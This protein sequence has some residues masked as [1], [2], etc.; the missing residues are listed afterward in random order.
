MPDR[1]RP[2]PAR[3]A[4]GLGALLLL[5]LLATAA[6]AAPP[7]VDLGVVVYQA[8]ADPAAGRL[9]LQVVN[10]GRDPVTVTRATLESSEF[11]T[12]LEWTKAAGSTVAPGRRLDLAVDLAPV[13]CDG[14]EA[15]S[16]RTVELDVV[17]ASGH[18][19][20][21]R[22]AP[23]DAF[24]QV[25]RLVAESCFAEELAAIAE[26]RISGLEP[27]ADPAA[28]AIV[29]VDVSPGGADGR[30]RVEALRG[31]TLLSPADASGAGRDEVAVGAVIDASA[32]SVR[33]PVVPA[34]CDAHA[35]SED[36][37]GTILPLH[38]S[39]GEREGRLLLAAPD[40]V[41]TALYAYVARACG[42]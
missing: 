34:R 8:R 31:T 24:G 40:A 27:P 15:E 25:A 19:A 4:A 13:A 20:T 42:F 5:P 12:P 38:V 14:A 41:R 7:T 22:V 3:R 30:Y 36:K 26:L 39:A 1:S 16:P 21:V 33:L 2:R 28:P 23:D 32:G 29:V 9:Q 18:A 35:V 17:D 11:A 6:C 37:Q 10:A